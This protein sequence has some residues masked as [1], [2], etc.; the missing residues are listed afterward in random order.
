[1]GQ[2]AADF[3]GIPDYRHALAQ[4]YYNRGN[5][6]KRQDN[7]VEAIAAYRQA[8][9]ILE[10]LTRDFP[11]NPMYLQHLE[12]NANALGRL[13]LDNDQPAEAEAAFRTAV[14]AGERL[15][16]LYPENPGSRRRPGRQ[17]RQPGHRNPGR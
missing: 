3:R 14:A 1:M 17:L 8:V 2:L 4:S 11:R 16:A 5:L 9:G 10:T 6:L 12:E 15:V 13:L 7:P